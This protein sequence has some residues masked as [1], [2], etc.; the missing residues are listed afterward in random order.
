MGWEEGELEQGGQGMGVQD[1]GL[2]GSQT[3]PLLH[4]SVESVEQAMAV[5]SLLLPSTSCSSPAS[6]SSSCSL[7]WDV[8]RLH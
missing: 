3:T 4:V 7:C 5:G 2:P 6:S 8:S 1:L